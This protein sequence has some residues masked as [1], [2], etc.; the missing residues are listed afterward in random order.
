[1]IG[2][3]QDVGGGGETPWN[4]AKRSGFG[5]HGSAEGHRQ[6][7]QVREVIILRIHYLPDLLGSFDT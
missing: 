5:F 3:N 2:I 1:M 7:S 4:G 6:F